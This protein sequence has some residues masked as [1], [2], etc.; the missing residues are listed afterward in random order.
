VRR[1]VVL[2]RDAAGKSTLARR[3]G[4]ATGLPVVELD[5]LFWRPDLTPT[6]AA[7][8]A[9]EQRALAARPAWIAD[10]DLG[11]YDDALD[12]RLAAADTVVLLDFGLVR[13]AWRAVRRSRERGDF[14]RWVV[15][16]RRRWRPRILA[17]VAAVA[18]GARLHVLRT[19]R[20][21]RRFLA[22]HAA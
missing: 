3:L 6:P 10:G 14:W 20:A 15:G 19:P 5:R 1:V 13:C 11:P 8:W 4:A 21:V 12:V 7:E 17:R 22:A 16:Y 2:G 9:A 18:P